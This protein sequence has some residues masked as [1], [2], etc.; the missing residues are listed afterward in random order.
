MSGSTRLYYW[1]DQHTKREYDVG[2]LFEGGRGELKTA[3]LRSEE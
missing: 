1:E 2:G 3:S